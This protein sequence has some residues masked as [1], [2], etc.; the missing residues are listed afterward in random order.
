MGEEDV[1]AVVEQGVTVV[2]QGG[3][4]DFRLATHSHKLATMHRIRCLLVDPQWWSL[5]VH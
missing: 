1:A 4:G 3:G 2:E 5:Q